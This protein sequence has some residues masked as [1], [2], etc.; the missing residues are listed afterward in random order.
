ML[1]LKLG[2]VLLLVFMY[3]YLTPRHLGWPWTVAIFCVAL[4]INAAEHA[5]KQKG[6]E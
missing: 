4:A 2:S 1:N 6:R 5:A 3:F